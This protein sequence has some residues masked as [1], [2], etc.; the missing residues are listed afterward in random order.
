MKHINSKVITVRL[1][2]Q[3]PGGW[4]LINL[5]KWYPVVSI[6]P[7]TTEDDFAVSFLLNKRL[8]VYD[9]KGH[10]FVVAV[11]LAVYKRYE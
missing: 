11:S 7:T 3:L 9:A 4:Y 5:N 2:A 10:E 1:A 6:V 8:V